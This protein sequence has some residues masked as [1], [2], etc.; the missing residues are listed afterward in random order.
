MTTQ[1]WCLPVH[2]GIVIDAN[3]DITASR[4]FKF[5]FRIATPEQIAE[6][7]ELIAKAKAARLCTKVAGRT[8]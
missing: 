2:D 3:G 6:A 8:I 1:L 4:N 5:E 7:A